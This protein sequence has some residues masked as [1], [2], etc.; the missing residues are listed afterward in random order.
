M[1]SESIEDA[2]R[3]EP[4]V[5]PGAGPSAPYPLPLD[6][7]QY[8]VAPSNFGGPI[9]YVPK[10]TE[11][12]PSDAAVIFTSSTGKFLSHHINQYMLEMPPDNT[13]ALVD[14]SQRQ[15]LVLLFSDGQAIYYHGPTD[16][17]PY[18]NQLADELQDGDS[19]LMGTMKSG[20]KK[21]VLSFV[22]SNLCLFVSNNIDGE[23]PSTI[24]YDEL[25]YLDSTRPPICMAVL[26]S[27]ADGGDGES[28]VTST[29]VVLP[30]I[31]MGIIVVEADKD[32]PEVH[33]N[34]S[35]SDNTIVA[36]SS[37]PTLNHICLCTEDLK[38]S[39]HCL[40]GS[41][42]FETIV[43]IKIDNEIMGN[44]FCT[45]NELGW[46]PRN[47]SNKSSSSGGSHD[48]LM[49]LSFEKPPWCSDGW[50]T[51][52]VDQS[53]DSVLRDYSDR[54]H[55]VQEID[56]V[57]IVSET[58]GSCEEDELIRCI[59]SSTMNIFNPGSISPGAM[60]KDAKR[61]L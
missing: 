3:I 58:G 61:K 21:S 46:C 56:G 20:Q 11:E 32:T 10:V 28:I 31:G 44:S 51:I 14:W 4:F 25:S 41:G 52:I 15:T 6:P 40:D 18:S 16:K 7:T 13:L 24:K 47:G 53:G 2:V 48:G 34:D 57:R 33:S 30:C 50:G 29:R 1:M 17:K 12:R 5:T 19:V 37:H 22:T 26:P 39:V 36:M 8:W 55:I 54:V 27:P 42:S 45:P 9:A 59:P 35:W 60:L 49:V 38:A 43:S 23:D